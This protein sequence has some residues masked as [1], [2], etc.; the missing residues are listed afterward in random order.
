MVATD[1]FVAMKLDDERGVRLLVV[2]S[3]RCLTRFARDFPPDPRSQPV[4][5]ALS[6]DGTLVYT[7]PNTLCGQD[8]YDPLEL[9]RFEVGVRGE[10]PP[11]AAATEPGHLMISEGRILAMSENGKFV[12]LHSTEDGK[13]LRLRTSGREVDARLGTGALAWEGTAMHPAGARLYVVGQRSLRAI[14]LAQAVEEWPRSGLDDAFVTQH[15]AIGTDYVVAVDSL[16]GQRVVD[17]RAAKTYRLNVYSRKLLMSEDGTT[18]ESGA[19]QFCPEVVEPSGISKFQG[20]DGGFYYLTGDKRL[21]F[22]K[23]AGSE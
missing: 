15:L 5:I 7:L 14:N 11:F 8:L 12:R 22:L 19:R 3:Y 18:T 16:S 1:D 4:N 13:P 6:A 21:V 2:D 9:R 17:G 23:G 10:G 20:V